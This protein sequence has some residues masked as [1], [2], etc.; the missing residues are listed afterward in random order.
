MYFPLNTSRATQPF[1]IVHMDLWGPYRIPTYDKKH[2]LLTIVND[3]YQSL[4]LMIKTQFGSLVKT[5]K[6][7]NSIKI[8]NTQCKD[9]FQRLGIICQSSV[10]T[11]QQNGIVER[12]NKYILN[13]SRAIRF[14]SH[15]YIEF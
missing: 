9:L 15:M 13:V 14:Q 4:F 12:E 10:Y 6:S 1:D 3:R 5:V 8:F 2:Y 7:Y 11:P